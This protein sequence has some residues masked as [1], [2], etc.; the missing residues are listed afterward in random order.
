MI[1][2]AEEGECGKIIVGLKNSR[3][4]VILAKIFRDLTVGVLMILD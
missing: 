2:F 3:P 1:G 4:V